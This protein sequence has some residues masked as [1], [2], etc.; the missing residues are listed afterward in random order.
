LR[1]DDFGPRLMVEWSDWSVDRT[2][3]APSSAISALSL[4]PVMLGEDW[5]SDHEE[6]QRAVTNSSVPRTWVA[7][8]IEGG[9]RMLPDPLRDVTRVLWVWCRIPMV[10]LLPSQRL[11]RQRIERLSSGRCMKLCSQAMDRLSASWAA[12]EV[13]LA[14][15]NGARNAR[16]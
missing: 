6:L 9:V 11:A 5:W 4:F 15:S 14:A 16:A 7:E 2:G 8:R 13:F 1:T 12:D 10:Q 3:C